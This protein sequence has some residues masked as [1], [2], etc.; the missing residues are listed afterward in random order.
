[1]CSRVLQLDDTREKVSLDVLA[2]M[3]P[4]YTVG[5]S[6]VADL[7]CVDVDRPHEAL[8]LNGNTQAVSAE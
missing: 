2:D 8:F 3:A 4:Q 5:H 6:I 7:G 1:M